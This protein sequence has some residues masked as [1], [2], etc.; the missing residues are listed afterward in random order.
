MRVHAQSCPTSRPPGTAAR[1][2]LLSMGFS[3][4]EYQSGLPFSYSR[5]YSQTRAQTRVSCVS[6]IGRWIF[7]RCT[8]WEPQSLKV[9]VKSLSHV[10]LFATP[11]TATHQASLSFPTSRSLLKLMSIELL[12]L[13]TLAPWKCTHPPCAHCCSQQWSGPW[14]Q[15]WLRT[16]G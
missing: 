7:Y 11:W 14:S 16:C 8:T 3:R 10:Q 4:Q 1:Q 2:A 15:S 5:G 13:A 9:V 12:N 6:S